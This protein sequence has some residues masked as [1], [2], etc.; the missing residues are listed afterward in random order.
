MK[1]LAFRD[2]AGVCRGEDGGVGLEGKV[3]IGRWRWREGG[4]LLTTRE[5]ERESGNGVV[6]YQFGRCETIANY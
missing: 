3:G 4:E 6:S 2:A 5:R 1:W